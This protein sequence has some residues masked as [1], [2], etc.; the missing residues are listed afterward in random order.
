M[1]LLALRSHHLLSSF[2]FP[3]RIT[4]K[5]EDIY[6]IDFFIHSLRNDI[7]IIREL[8]PDLAWSTREFYATG[9]HENR[10]KFAPLHA[11]PSWYLRNVAPKLAV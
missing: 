11:T 1:S 5:F 3:S 9:V 10:V 2:F 7:R 4:S 6:D 8:P